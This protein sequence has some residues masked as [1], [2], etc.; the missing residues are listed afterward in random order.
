MI[1]NT[2]GWYVG[3]LVISDTVQLGRIGP[4]G[5]YFKILLGHLAR[6]RLELL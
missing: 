3:C 1:R 5:P 6:G 4:Y 2:L